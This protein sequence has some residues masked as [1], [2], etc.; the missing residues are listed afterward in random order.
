MKQWPSWRLG[1]AT[2]LLVM[3]TG[4]PVLAAQ[5]DALGHDIGTG[6]DYVE[7]DVEEWKEL[8]V[9]PPAFPREENLREF[10][11]SP[12]ATAK[13]LIDASTLAPGSDGVVRYVLVIR[14]AGGAQNISFE[15]IRCEENTWKLYATGSSDGQW[16]KA[17][18]SEWRPIENQ[19]VNRY[20]AALSRELFCPMGIP[21][22]TP[23]EGRN[24][25]K[26]GKHPNA[27]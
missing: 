11:V 8:D 7:P 6:I 3:A 10:Y 27:L 9:P 1:V 15:G 13:Y 20:H 12:T 19:P 24:A 16:H 25:L 17:R 14:T 23:D 4:K 5:K 21:I 2:L 26:L 18:I 22:A